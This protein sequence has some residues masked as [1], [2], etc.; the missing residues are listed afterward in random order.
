MS[1]RW[2]TATTTTTSRRGVGDNAT[3]SPPTLRDP[4]SQGRSGA[5]QARAGCRSPPRGVPCRSGSS[6][7]SVRREPQPSSVFREDPLGVP[8]APRRR[9]PAHRGGS[10][11]GSSSSVPV[12]RP[13]DLR[14]AERRPR[15]TRSAF[16]GSIVIS[17]VV[18][19]QPGTP[20]STTGSSILRSSTRARSRRSSRRTACSG[21]KARSRAADRPGSKRQVPA[22]GAPARAAVRTGTPGAFRRTSVRVRRVDHVRRQEAVAVARVDPPAS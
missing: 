19:G 8:R 11:R 16:A 4:A 14:R 15:R 10:R 12:D 2:P 18:R 21:S 5:A 9:S 3:A 6:S 1:L 7:S 22:Q 13:P 20:D 17:R